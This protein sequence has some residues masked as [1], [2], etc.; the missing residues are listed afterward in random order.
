M[1]GHWGADFAALPRGLPCNQLSERQWQLVS[2]TS[3]QIH[4]Q[5]QVGWHA[6]LERSGRMCTSSPFGS[7]RLDGACKA[8]GLLSIREAAGGQFRPAGSRPQPGK[9]DD[10]ALSLLCSGHL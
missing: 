2:H 4:M 3:L 5:L 6:P 9:P 10:E 7:A 8:A 1:A